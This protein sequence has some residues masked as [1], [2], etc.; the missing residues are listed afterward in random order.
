[1]HAGRSCHAYCVHG[2]IHPCIHPCGQPSPYA[3][4]PAL[5]C[6][7]GARAWRAQVAGE[8][9]M[10]LDYK[11]VTYSA[12][13]LP[14]GVILCDATQFESPSAFSIYIKRKTNPERCGTRM[15]CMHGRTRIHP[16]FAWAATRTQ[17]R[18]HAWAIPPH[19]RICVHAD[20]WQVDPPCSWQAPRRSPA[21][22]TT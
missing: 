11:G 22:S 4:W 13:L 16:R 9:V 21:G 7:G 14:N 12:D 20:Q 19:G 3:I 17:G 5:P 1:M 2:C 10:L 8:G 6:P 15:G 18:Q